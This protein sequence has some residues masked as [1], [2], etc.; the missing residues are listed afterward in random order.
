MSDFF[1]GEIRMFSFSWAPD[2][3]ALCDGTTMTIQQN[4]A[5]YSLLGT[6]YG[7]NAQ[8]TFNLPDLR[9]RVPVHFG[10]NF[11]PLVTYQQ[12]F[13]AG[14]EQV[15]L[16]TNNVPQ[17][18]HAIS[19]VTS[20]ADTSSAQGNFIAT[21]APDNVQMENRPPYGA[22]SNLVALNAG[23]VSNTGGNGAHP[24]MQPFLVT[25]FCIA[26]QGLYPPRS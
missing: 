11:T 12:G 8:T 9:G 1:L 6:T 21:T 22:P 7:G 16:T 5:L 3:W 25:N 14:V 13:A 26:L 17:H 10:R 20:V 19:A 4:Q 24:N 2:C 23:I 18:N 15:T